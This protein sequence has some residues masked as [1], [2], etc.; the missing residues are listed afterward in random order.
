MTSFVSNRKIQKPTSLS[1]WQHIN[2]T[3][4]ILTTFKIINCQFCLDL[5]LYQALRL[6][7]F[8]MDDHLEPS[9]KVHDMDI[10]VILIFKMEKVRH[11]RFSVLSKFHP[12]SE[13]WGGLERQ[14]FLPQPSNCC[15]GE[16]QDLSGATGKWG[17]LKNEGRMDWRVKILHKT[18]TKL[19]TCSTLWNHNTEKAVVS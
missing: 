4:I 13:W 12:D 10:F 14:P 18:L 19:F 2:N 17:S 1:D 8:S 5:R 15:I 3:R 16:Q 11:K 9:Q 6:G 7:S